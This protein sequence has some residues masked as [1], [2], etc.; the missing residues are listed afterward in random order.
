MAGGSALRYDWMVL[1]SLLWS[2]VEVL[3]L[4][5]TCLL[6]MT[7]SCFDFLCAAG[8]LGWPSS[9]ISKEER[10]SANCEEMAASVDVV[11]VVLVVLVIGEELTLFL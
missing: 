2:G 6:V 4:N 7:S 11:V 10:R 1:T 8:V 3:F 5:M 9:M